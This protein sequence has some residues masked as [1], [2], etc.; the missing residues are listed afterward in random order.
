MSPLLILVIPLAL[1]MI[2]IVLIGFHIV[3]DQPA[4]SYQQDLAFKRT[5]ERQANA[6]I[7][8]QQQIVSR[9]RA[10]LSRRLAIDAL[11]TI[12]V[13]PRARLQQMKHAISYKN[14]LIRGESFQPTQ[15]SGWIPRYV[16]QREPPNA[17]ADPS[18]SGHDRLDKAFGSETEAD[19][20]AVQDA[21]SW[22]DNS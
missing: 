3:H 13:G 21:K 8:H 22:I 18:P 7:I 5:A 4:F 15:S 20:F 12:T 2:G 14:Y 9:V 16:L 19:E 1:T 11:V 6:R 17:D 10:A